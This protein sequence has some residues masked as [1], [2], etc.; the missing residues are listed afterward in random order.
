[1]FRNSEFGIPEARFFEIITFRMSEFRNFRISTI[2]EFSIYEAQNLE[3]L[4]NYEISEF[5]RRQPPEDIVVELPHAE[6]D[7]A[8]PQRSAATG[9]RCSLKQ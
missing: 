9:C 7:T 1:M 6:S 3:A 8:T 4:E 2:P 5:Q